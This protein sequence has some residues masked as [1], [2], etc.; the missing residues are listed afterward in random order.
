MKY[1][2]VIGFI[3][4]F[5]RSFKNT[6]LEITCGKDSMV[7]KNLNMGRGSKFGK[8]YIG[9]MRFNSFIVPLADFL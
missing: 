3:T 7:I 8:I 6:F 2:V 4:N 1:G 9:G 5:I